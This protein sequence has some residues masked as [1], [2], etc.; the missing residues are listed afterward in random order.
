MKTGDG[1]AVAVRV[2]AGARQAGVGGAW[3][4]ADGGARLVVSVRAPAEDGKANAAVAAALAEAFGAPKSAV[5]L[6]SGGTAR[7]KT[8]HVRGDAPALGVR[9]RELLQGERN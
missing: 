6:K 2:T 8:F 9:L 5:S 3:K 4:G 7:L 1:I